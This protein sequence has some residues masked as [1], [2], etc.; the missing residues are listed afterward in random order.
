MVKI[1]F[2]GE[3]KTE[4]LILQSAGFQNWLQQNGINCVGKVID[5]KGSGN[6]L[7]NRIEAFL[8][9][10]YGFEADKIVI[11]TDLDNDRTIEVTQ[12][13]IGR[14]DI[15][16]VLVA[17]KTIEAW[18]LSDSAL[19]SKLLNSPVYIDYPE[20]FDNAFQEIR[21]IFEHKT[22]RGIGT[23]PMLAR[24]L[25]KYGFTIQQAAR[26]PNCPSAAYFLSTLQTL[27][28]AN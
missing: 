5:A 6:L 2:I 19:M 10:L 28:S 26:H 12:Q 27:A 14:S 16:I 15:Q 20:Q 9:E 13:R 4:Q 8:D 18:F 3:G 23:K 21:R 17:V 22:G 11:L 24:H 1:G 25:L 7:P